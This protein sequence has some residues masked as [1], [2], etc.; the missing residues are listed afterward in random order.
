MATA[1]RPVVIATNGFGRP[2]VDAT[3]TSGIGDPVTIAT[4][5]YGE[6][7][8]L[9]ANGIGKPVVFKATSFTSWATSWEQATFGAD[10]PGWASYTLRIRINSAL[11]AQ[12]GARSRLTFKASAAGGFVL[13][14]VRMQQAAAAGDAYDFASTPFVFTFSGSTGVTC[15]AGASVVSDE[16]AFAIDKTKD[17]IVA[18]HFTAA[19]AAISGQTGVSGA[20]TYFKA[21]VN[22]CATVDATGY[23]TNTAGTLR[24][25]TKIE[26]GTVL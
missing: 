6:P 26:A 7:V 13:D 14:D 16:M 20:N 1:A 18:V 15:G 8:V 19:A 5:G 9:A 3:A 24:L 21:A 22:D 25:L 17:Y 23:T 10:S 11:L 12:S 4:N 2:V